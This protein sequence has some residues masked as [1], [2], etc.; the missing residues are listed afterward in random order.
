MIGVWRTVNAM[1]R[2]WRNG[3]RRAT[4]SCAV[5]NASKRKR[6]TLTLPVYAGSRRQIWR[7][8]RRF[9]VLVAD[10]EVVLR[11]IRRAAFLQLVRGCTITFAL[12]GG[13]QKFEDSVGFIQWSDAC[14]LGNDDQRTN[15][16]LGSL[17]EDSRRH[18]IWDDRGGIK[19]FGKHHLLCIL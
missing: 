1:R 7:R 18:P 4:R 17:W 14:H 9:N 11:V 8:I 6:Q 2:S 3:R 16:F 12:L 13:L 19:Q 15:V 10:A 5:L